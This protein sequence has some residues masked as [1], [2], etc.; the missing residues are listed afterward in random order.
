MQQKYAKEGLVILAVTMDGDTDKAER[1]KYLAKTKTFLATKI[2]P[3]FP[4]YDLDFDRDKPPA[5]LTWADGNPRVFVFNRDNQYSLRLP[6]VDKSREVV[7][8]VENAEVE[9]AVV[10]ALKTK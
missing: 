1:A 10:E 8:A 6:V 5:T 9:K 7:K 4:A 2:K 3:P